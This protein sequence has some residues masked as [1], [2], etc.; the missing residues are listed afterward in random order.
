VPPI[1]PEN[2]VPIPLHQQGI[3]PSENGADKHKSKFADF[4]ASARDGE[5]AP[6]DEFRDELKDRIRIVPTERVQPGDN[7]RTEFDQALLDEL[8]AS[9]AKHGQLVPILATEGP[10]G[11]YTIIDGERRYRAMQAAGVSTVRLIV[12]DLPPADARAVSV[13]ANVQR[14]GLTAL[15]FAAVCARMRS[16]GMAVKAIAQQLGKGESTISNAIRMMELPASARDLVMAGRVAATAARALL[17]PG[18]PDKVIALQMEAQAARPLPVR[19]LEKPLPHIERVL[20]SGLAINLESGEKR[21]LFPTKPCHEA[22]PHSAYVR[23][24]DWPYDICL[25]PACCA[26][27]NRAVQAERAAAAQ[28]LAEEAKRR[29]ARTQA[30]RD[31]E[32]AGKIAKR[33]AGGATVAQAESSEAPELRGLMDADALP[34]DSYLSFDYSKP[35]E[36]CTEACPNRC[37]LKR[38]G[39]AFEACLDPACHKRLTMAATR[40]S[41]KSARAHAKTLADLAEIYL[42]QPGDARDLALLI[43]RVLH[44]PEGIWRSIM[45]DEIREAFGLPAVGFHDAT[46]RKAWLDAAGAMPVGELLRCVRT[47]IVRDEMAQVAERRSL[48]MPATEWLLSSAEEG[49]RPDPPAA[50]AEAMQGEPAV[51]A[52]IESASDGSQTISDDGARRRDIGRPPAIGQPCDVCPDGGCDMRDV[53]MAYDGAAALDAAAQAKDWSNVWAPCKRCRKLIPAGTPGRAATATRLAGTLWRY[54][55]GVVWDREI[56]GNVY[57][58]DCSR[59]LRYCAACGATEEWLFTS[60]RLWLDGYDGICSHD[61]EIH[62]RAREDQ[63]ARRIRMSDAEHLRQVQAPVPGSTPLGGPDSDLGVGAAIAVDDLVPDLVGGRR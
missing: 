3:R 15:E 44:P 33:A 31:L 20:D 4:L 30:V 49:S 36:G 5:P 45:R 60:G 21:A 35:P 23:R 46:Q 63:D 61:D 57:C 7:P 11:R 22:C 19:D 53:C 1:G 10:E 52:V 14:A 40:A 39:K 9:I 51:A 56:S 47:M 55:T 54:E 48:T 13:V 59:D 32:G 42:A 16:E 2:Y 17:Q 50:G 26:E 25:N 6:E 24:L 28:K 62:A 41:N 34:H 12:R 18:V 8:A 37:R 43:D 27:K 29:G 58:V 38:Y